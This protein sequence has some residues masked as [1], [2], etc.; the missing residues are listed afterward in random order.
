MNPID[1]MDRYAWSWVL[2]PYG[3]GGDDFRCIDC[4]GYAQEILASVGEDPP[5]DQTAQSLYD[6]ML[7]RE[8]HNKAH[9]GAWAFY[10]KHAGAITHIGWITNSLSMLSA[11]G[12]GSRVTSPELAVKHN[13][14]VK[15][16]SI[17]YRE[18]LVRIIRPS[19][20]FESRIDGKSL[21]G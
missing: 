15:P 13:A 8:R 12:G 11:A 19:Y 20:R 17:Y 6:F 21:L 7:T 10:G 5:G 3:W 18:D 16:R 14:F 2:T 4:S 1:V 9:R